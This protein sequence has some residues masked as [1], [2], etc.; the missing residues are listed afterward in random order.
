MAKVGEGD[1]RWVVRDRE[2]GKNVGN[3]HW[4]GERD[5]L[6]WADARLKALLANSTGP[7]TKVTKV[8]NVTGDANLYN[9]KGALRAVFDVKVSGEWQTTP[10]GTAGKFAFELFDSDPDITAS[11]DAKASSSPSPDYSA[12]SR[13]LSECAP[14]F[15]AA[16]EAFAADMAAGVPLGPEGAAAVAAAAAASAAAASASAAAAASTQPPSLPDRDVDSYTHV[17]GVDADSAAVRE[18]DL[19]GKPH[20]LTDIFTCAP[21]DLYMAVAGERARL[22]AVTRA[23]ATCNPSEGGAWVV[24]GGLATA[25]F[26]EAPKVGERVVFRKWKLRDWGAED[27]GV[28]VALDF[29]L[30]D[31]G[32]TLLTVSV[33][34]LPP[35]RR[36]PVEGFWRVQLFQACKVVL[37]Y[38]SASGLL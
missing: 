10:D 12:K 21:R 25:E 2:D 1:P 27:P 38:G 7:T 23:R 24:C 20:V 35:E 30:Q 5:C 16:A 31:D 6:P 34:E 29:A 4:S 9:R 17:A 18:R 19:K 3:W 11:I 33:F 13:F 14:A 28:N 32:R 15:R 36:S 22:E 26:A 37:G 8:N